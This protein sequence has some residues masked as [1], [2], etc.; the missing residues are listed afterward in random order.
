M[1]RIRFILIVVASA[2]LAL[3][4][5]A[6]GGGSV[7]TVVVHSVALQGNLLGDTPDRAVTVYLPPGYDDTTAR[8][9]VLYLLH[10]YGQEST[11]WVDR[12]LARTLDKLLASGAVQ[13]LIVVTPDAYNRYGGSFYADSPVT[14]HWDAFVSRELVSYVDANYRT[15]ARPESR[16]IAGYGMG[17]YGALILALEHPD[18]Y[19]AV[20]AMS[21]VD[22]DL[23]G[24]LKGTT[25]PATAFTSALQMLSLGIVPTSGLGASQL[26][27]AAA[28]SPN[29]DSPP[30]Y[31]DLPYELVDGVPQRVD[32]VWQ[33]WE[34]HSP[35]AMLERYGPNL[36]RFQG[37]GFDVGAFDSDADC[38]TGARALSAA[39]TR[40]GIDHRYEEYGGDPYYQLPS[41]MGSIVLPFLSDH[42]EGEAAVTD[43]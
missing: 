19:R 1:G 33:R 26:A 29:V 13:P 35:L 28:L 11:Y 37:I 16:A 2:V 21:A 42:V 39:L 6:L 12:G 24:E 10:G 40:A 3:I 15:L 38:V 22:I 23:T 14:G 7:T 32:A 30:T 17:G 20:Y 18:T 43:E 5:A 4:P 8:Y 36:A 27:R 9:P 31:A 34:A 25:L 41:R